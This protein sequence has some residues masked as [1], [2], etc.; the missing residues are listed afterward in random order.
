MRRT[1][2]TLLIVWL[3]QLLLANSWALASATVAHAGPHSSAWA[4]H[5]CHDSGAPTSGHAAEVVH[6]ASQPEPDGQQPAH[7]THN[8]ASA[9]SADSHHCCAVGLSLG[10]AALL[11]P[12][13]QAAPQSVSLPWVSLSVRPDLRPPI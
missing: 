4:V 1:V 10:S 6:T 7:S 13:P 9:T 12:L 8:P 11:A 3:L 2:W 5:A